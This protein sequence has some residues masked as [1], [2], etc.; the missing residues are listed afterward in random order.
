MARA[1]AERRCPERSARVQELARFLAT[2]EMHPGALGASA[3]GLVRQH[4]VDHPHVD[5]CHHHARS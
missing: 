4:V 3:R 5:S 2:L 1:S